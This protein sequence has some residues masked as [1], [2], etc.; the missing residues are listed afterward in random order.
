MYIVFWQNFVTEPWLLK[1]QCILLFTGETSLYIMKFILAVYSWILLLSHLLI[2]YWNI[3]FFLLRK[4]LSHFCLN[5]LFS[6]SVAITVLFQA[7]ISSLTQKTVK[8]QKSV[9]F[10]DL[11]DSISIS[12]DIEDAPNKPE[13]TKTFINIALTYNIIQKND[14]FGLVDLLKN[15]HIEQFYRHCFYVLQAKVLC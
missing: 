8:S 13:V 11:G 14:C 10:E 1:I 2:Y 3:Y 4:F 9:N 5:K 7:Y 12:S 15:M 6:K